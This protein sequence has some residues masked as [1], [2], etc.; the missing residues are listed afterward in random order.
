[1]KGQLGTGLIPNH[2][3]SYQ[4]N[5]DFSILR[6]NQSSLGLSILGSSVLAV[7]IRSAKQWRLLVSSYFD[8]WR[9]AYH[10]SRLYFQTTFVGDV[11]SMQLY[12][13]NPTTYP[14]Q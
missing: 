12:L 6:S 8:Q 5:Q 11:V 14:K 1:M 4:K 7:S 9:Y 13:C 10:P 2:L 3:T